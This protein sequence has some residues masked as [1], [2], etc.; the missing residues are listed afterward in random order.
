MAGIRIPI[1]NYYGGGNYTAPILVGSQQTPVNVILDTGSSTLAIKPSA[2][3]PLSDTNLRATAFVQD[4]IYGTGGWAGPLVTTSLA[5]G[6]AG[7]T[8]SIADGSLALTLA[9][10]PNNFGAADGILGL[11][12]DELNDAYNLA[13]YLQQRGTNPA[14]T[15]PWPLAIQNSQSALK[16]F[17]KFIAAMPNEKVP[18]FFTQLVRQNLTANK[19][20][21]YTKRSTPKGNNQQ[22]P[23]NQGC[24]I[25]GGGEEQADLYQG[26][27]LN[28]DVVHDAYY[29][30]NLKAVQVGNAA[31]V[32]AK[33]LPQQFVPSMVSN[34]MI[35][36]GTHFL[37]LSAD[38][39][40]AIISALGTIDPRLQQIV[41]QAV[42]A[43]AQGQ[44][45]PNGTLQ[46]ADWPNITFIMTG[47]H[48]EDVPLVCSPQTYWQLDSSAVGTATFQINAKG[49]VVSV[50]GLPLFNNYFTV[51]DRSADASGVVRFAPIK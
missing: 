4:N 46:L 29:N 41:Q 49:E 36:S 15:W 50:L 1:T 14:V 39:Y 9:R 18:P 8:V 40:Q 21:F 16:Q 38:V 44:G 33:P 42:Q 6:V 30:T 12:Y 17:Q 31:P 45:I 2:Y 35:D 32:A 22:D 47:E 27:F 34:S 24:F 51:F 7:N 43:Q 20:A 5:M 26:A 28:V 10:E 25:L 13:A 48:G 19:F 3:D 37:A 23:A 11:A